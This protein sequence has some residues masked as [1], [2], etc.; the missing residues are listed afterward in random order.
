ME[1]SRIRW[2][3]LKHNSLERAQAEFLM[4]RLGNPLLEQRSTKLL[5]GMYLAFNFSE[6]ESLLGAFNTKKVMVWTWPEKQKVLEID[7]KDRVYT[8]ISFSGDKEKIF[9]TDSKGFF[10]L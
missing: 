1:L 9:L 3:F 7:S 10:T 6:D 2:R 8:S 4:N 5:R